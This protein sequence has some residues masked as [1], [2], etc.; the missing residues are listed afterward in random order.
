M[1][2][3]NAHTLNVLIRWLVPIA[4]AIVFSI[5]FLI[6]PPGLLGKADALGYAVCHRIDERSFHLGGRQLPLCARCSG[7]YLG[8]MLGIVFQMAIARRR[9]GNPPWKVIVPLILFFLA[10]AVDGTNSYIYLIKTVSPGGLDFLPTLYI[11][12]N[13]LRLFTGSGM[14]LVIAAAIYPAFN[15]TV[16][17]DWEIKPALAD[18]KS[19]G[20]LVALMIGLDLLT[21][22]ESPIVLY[23]VAFISAGGVLVLF[24]MIYSMVWLMVMRQ[25]NAFT[26]IKQM[27][28]ALLAGLTISLIQIT[29]I[30]LVRF[31]ATGTWSGFPLG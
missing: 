29:L 31:W 9:G 6:S 28:M 1:Q 18:L 10:F 13:T 11:P 21:L 20:I 24:K 23:P 8:A 3:R 27:G 12:N 25:E 5:W 22:T 2:T 19:L 7:M 17:A 30:D 14:G 4:A 16:R 15:Q 26:S